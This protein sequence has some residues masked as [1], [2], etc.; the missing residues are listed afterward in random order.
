[1]WYL[2]RCVLFV[3]LAAVLHQA[4]ALNE[5]PLLLLISFDGFRYDLLNAS[6]VPNIW[7]FAQKGV[8]FVNGSRSQYLTYTAP[9][10]ASIVTGLLESSHG[11]VANSFYDPQSR[12]VY[13]LFN[14]TKKQGIV[15]ASLSQ[16]F[17]NGE[18]IWLT[19]ERAANNRHSASMFWPAGDATWPSPPHKPTL[20]RSW[21]GY[22]NRTQWMADFD[23]IIDL[24]FRES[25]PM[26]FVAWYVAEPDHTLHLNGFYNGEL[27]KMLHELDLLFEYVVKKITNNR[28]LAEKLNIILTADHGHAE[29]KS[30]SDVF[31]ISEHVNMSNMHYGDN[32][33][34]VENET[35]RENTYSILKK[36][37]ASGG[38]GVE[39]FL[40]KDFP[41]RYGYAN[42]PRVGDIILEPRVGSAVHPNCTRK[43][44]EAR[45][46]SGNETF[47]MS[48]HGMDPDN[49]MMR[50]L[51]VMSGPAFQQNIQIHRT[52]NNV[53]LYALMCYVLGIV[54]APNN[55]SVYSLAFA[56]SSSFS[57]PQNPSGVLL[58]NE[59]TLA[60]AAAVVPTLGLLLFYAVLCC[61]SRTPDNTLDNAFS[62]GYRPLSANQ[63]PKMFPM[64]T[65]SE[66]FHNGIL[67]AASSED[68]L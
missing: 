4:V 2:Q 42:S 25:D 8:N 7:K 18:P 63:N 28:I 60:I 21:S 11:I 59:M 55:G 44:I 14:E 41:A 30:P 34:Y 5:N 12:S 17:Y 16:H 26:N 38:Y 36:A 27:R 24:F 50:A 33:L 9:N 54:E 10:H 6:L 58:A 20:A 47:H 62:K 1:M 15:N 53:D 64:Q 66:R 67:I 56:L 52:V 37:I 48:A 46:K 29:I 3:H 35:L 13:D 40:K 61:S 45:F 51:L 43:E 65:G 57:G 39:V 32:M 49:W 23:F 68:E 22:K 19:N 31:C